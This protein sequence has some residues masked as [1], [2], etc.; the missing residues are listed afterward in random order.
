MFFVYMFH[1]LFVENE[2]HWTTQIFL[3]CYLVYINLLC[4]LQITQ[5]VCLSMILFFEYS[6]LPSLFGSN[7][8][9]DSSVEISK[10]IGSPPVKVPGNASIFLRMPFWRYTDQCIEFN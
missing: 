3:N 5:I 4:C 2:T 8:S 10:T 7:L 1:T 9:G 6:F